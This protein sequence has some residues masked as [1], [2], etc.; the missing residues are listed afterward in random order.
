MRRIKRPKR[1]IKTT[2][3][4]QTELGEISFVL[5]RSSARK[6]LTITIDEKS[7]VGVASPFRMKEREIVNFINEKAQWIIKKVNEAQK[8][9]VILDQKKFDHGDQFLFLGKKFKLTI[10]ER[11]IKRSHVSFNELEGWFVTVPKELSIGERRVKVKEK[12]LQWYRAQAE[13]VLGGRIFH[14]SRLIS[15]EPKKIAVRTQKRIWGCCD[16]NTQTIHL[17]WQII[18]SPIKVIDYV[19]VHELC[20]LMVP[21]HSKRFWIKVEKYMPDFKRYKQWLTV[22]HLDMALP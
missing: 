19:V 6:T 3:S 2:C 8:N 15:I 14:F 5:T 16:Y 18:L 9:K 12:M 21:N 10:F 4:T 11:D 7:D 1:I 20:H 22:N 13:E 17:N